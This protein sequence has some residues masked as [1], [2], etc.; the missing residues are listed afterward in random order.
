MVQKNSPM[1]EKLRRGELVIS[2]KLN[3]ADP[4]VAELAAYAGFDCIWVDMEHVPV[5]Y[6]EIQTT[7]YAAKARGAETIVR[8]PR[9]AYS[10]LVR[11][12]EMDAAAIMVP[13]VMSKEDAQQVAY[14]TKFHPI[15]RRPIDGGNGDGMYCLM[16]TPDYIRYSNEQKLTIIQIEDIEAYEAVDEI[17]AVPGIDMLFFGP[18]DFAHSLGI[19]CDLSDPRVEEAR[20]GVAEAAHRHG[21]LAGTVGGV[22]NLAKLYAMGYRLVNI[23]ADVAGLGTYYQG[24]KR[25]IGEI[26]VTL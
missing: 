25:Q 2:T 24:L 16:N 23:G 14:Y 1:V 22:G 13:H 15:G 18:A 7:M 21:K 19:P 9:G 17:A 12:L 3:I 10:N 8:T 6:K 20:K 5:D 11:P 26:V 4:I